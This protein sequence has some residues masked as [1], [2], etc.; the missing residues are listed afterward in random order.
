Q[1]AVEVETLRVRLPGAFREDPRPGNGEPVRGRAQVL[2]QRNVLLVA[3]G[4]VICDVARVAILDLPWRVGVRV[5]DRWAFPVLV[6]CTFV[7]VCRSGR[8]PVKVMGKRSR[9]RRV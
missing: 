8:A 2:H 9:G 4:V 5:P 7:L 1:T 6:P 3:V